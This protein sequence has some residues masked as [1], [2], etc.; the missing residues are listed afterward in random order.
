MH[1]GNGCQISGDVPCSILHLMAQD[2]GAYTDGAI[3]GGITSLWADSRVR[4]ALTLC[5]GGGMGTPR[6]LFEVLPDLFPPFLT[7]I[8]CELWGKFL[9]KKEKG[10]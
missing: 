4:M 1:T 2:H 10:S 7:V 8:E 5:Y 9:S 3:I 6:F